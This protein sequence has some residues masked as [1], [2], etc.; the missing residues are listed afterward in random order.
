MAPRFEEVQANG[1]QAN[2]IQAPMFMAALREIQCIIVEIQRAVGNFI[3][4]PV[5]AGILRELQHEHGANLQI[6]ACYCRRGFAGQ[7]GHCEGCGHARDGNNCPC[8][9]CDAFKPP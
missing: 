4:R 9:S 5:P 6:V 2:G 7:G 8:A 3:R 1:V